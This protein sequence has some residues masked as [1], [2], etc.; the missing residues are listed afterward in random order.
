MI[1]EPRKDI[2][3]AQK[4]C[5]RVK[6]FF[7]YTVNPVLLS[8]IVGATLISLVAATVLRFLFMSDY[9]FTEVLSSSMLFAAVVGSSLVFLTLGLPVIVSVC[10]SAYGLAFYK[11]KKRAQVIA[12]I[13][14]GEG[15]WDIFYKRLVRP[16]WD[17]RTK[18]RFAFIELFTEYV[19]SSTELLEAVRTLRSLRARKQWD[20]LESDDRFTYHEDEGR[21]VV[22]E[23]MV[24]EHILLGARNLVN[25]HVIDHNKP[26][27]KV[28]ICI[29]DHSVERAV[30]FDLMVVVRSY[31]GY[32]LEDF[33]VFASTPLG[34]L[35]LSEELSLAM[36]GS[37]TINEP[38]SKEVA[39]R[40]S[41]ARIAYWESVIERLREHGGEQGHNSEIIA[42]MVNDEIEEKLTE[43]VI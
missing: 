18:F 23:S 29:V 10:K 17:E 15:V 30:L 40:M 25:T 26:V 4:L 11:Q 6:F 31:E 37:Y 12:D 22:S 14:M 43:K 35:G 8:F 5:S 33:L 24:D 42:L 7:K 36:N 28:F 19:E 16:Q 13:Q 21:W 20:Q 1:D 2:T 3:K 38:P 9:S 32:G 41:S 39:R 34:I 27:H